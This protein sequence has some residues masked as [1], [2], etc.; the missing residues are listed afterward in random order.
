[1]SKAT[2][3]PYGLD[4]DELVEVVHAA[5][6]NP[7]RFWHELAV[8]QAQYVGQIRRASGITRADRVRDV[9]DT[10]NRKLH[11]IVAKQ[12]INAEKEFLFRKH[13]ALSNFTEAINDAM[14]ARACALA[15][16]R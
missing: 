7:K 1:M 15:G 13:K 14:L 3:N 9:L 4:G 16:E 8:R 5:I 6:A 10:E 12:T 11:D 2:Q